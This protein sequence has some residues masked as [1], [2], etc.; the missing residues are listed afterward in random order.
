MIII[1]WEGTDCGFKSIPDME[2]K[3]KL[4]ECLSKEDADTIRKASNKGIR[5]FAGSNP[6]DA[7]IN[8]TLTMV[9][10]E[11]AEQLSNLQK[12]LADEV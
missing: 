6:Y 9:F 12:D 2:R 8:G 4:D 10:C 7:D 11:T 5:L 1:N 3:L